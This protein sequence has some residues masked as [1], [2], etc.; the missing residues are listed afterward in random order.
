MPSCPGT[1]IDLSNLVQALV[2]HVY[3]TAPSISRAWGEGV[4]DVGVVD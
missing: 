4:P 2:K 3:P 1:D